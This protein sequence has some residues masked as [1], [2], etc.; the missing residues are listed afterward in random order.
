M[1]LY[2]RVTKLYFLCH[3]LVFKIFFLYLSGMN[4][5]VEQFQKKRVLSREGYRTINATFSAE[6]F[7]SVEREAGK[8]GMTRVGYLRYLHQ[9][10]MEAQKISS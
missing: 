1:N 10:R 6:M 2:R 8:L 9:S 7:E 3:T 5:T 4:K